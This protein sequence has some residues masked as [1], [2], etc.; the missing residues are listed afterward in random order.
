MHIINHDKNY[1]QLIPMKYYAYGQYLNAF[2]GQNGH[3]FEVIWFYDA[4]LSI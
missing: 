3:L 4:N 1:S 2:A